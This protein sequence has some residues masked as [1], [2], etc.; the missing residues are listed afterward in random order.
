[1]HAAVGLLSQIK[2]GSFLPS[3]RNPYKDSSWN[4]FFW[5]EVLK[6]RHHLEEQGVDR[7]KILKWISKK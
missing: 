2:I 6:G 4:Y 5:S 1:V 7:R 3:G